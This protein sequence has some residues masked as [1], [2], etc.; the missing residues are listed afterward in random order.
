MNWFYRLAQV[1]T[2]GLLRDKALDLTRRFVLVLVLEKALIQ[3][4][5]EIRLGALLELHPRSGLK[6]LKGRPNW[7]RF[8]NERYGSNVGRPFRSNSLGRY[9]QA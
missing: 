2:P 8:V 6:M 1:F 3:V 7:G 4:C 5:I 9:T